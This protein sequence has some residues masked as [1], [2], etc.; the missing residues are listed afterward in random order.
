MYTAARSNGG[1]PAVDDEASICE[2]DIGGCCVGK[3]RFDA[4]NCC[5]TFAVICDVRCCRRSGGIDAVEFASVLKADVTA[6][7]IG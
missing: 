3:G 7:F 5:S 6:S 4:F 2:P 1:E